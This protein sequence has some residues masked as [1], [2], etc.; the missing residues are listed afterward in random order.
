VRN[1][2]RGLRKC[3]YDGKTIFRTWDQA[4]KALSRRAEPGRPYWCPMAGGYHMTRLSP[5]E[6]N[7]KRAEGD[8]IMFEEAVEAALTNAPQQII[9][10]SHHLA[11]PVC[12]ALMKLTLLAQVQPVQ[13]GVGVVETFDVTVG[14]DH[15]EEG[16]RSQSRFYAG[17]GK[18]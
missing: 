9:E 10:T 7:R 8:R 6:Y 17:V 18:L 1:R 2:G 14:L 15:A 16:H 11:C 5:D 4:R 13:T 12:G 3:R